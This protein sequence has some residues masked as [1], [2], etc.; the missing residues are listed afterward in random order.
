MCQRGRTDESGNG[1]GGQAHIW[2]RQEWEDLFVIDV[3]FGLD[4]IMTDSD[5]GAEKE[6]R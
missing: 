1:N 6:Y 4:F 3:L 2:E 5:M